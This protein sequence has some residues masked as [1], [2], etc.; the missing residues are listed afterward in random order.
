MADFATLADAEARAK[1]KVAD[2]TWLNAFAARATTG[3]KFCVRVQRK[4]SP[5]NPSNGGWVEITD[6]AAV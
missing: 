3:G 6:D 2:G 4:M 1:A 5:A